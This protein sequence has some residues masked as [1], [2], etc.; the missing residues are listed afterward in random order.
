MIN[1]L[2]RQTER[3]AVRKT[4]HFTTSLEKRKKKK[5]CQEPEEKEVKT[6]RRR[7]RSRTKSAENSNLRRMARSMVRF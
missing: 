6:E 7:R 1:C 5:K 2:S 3:S 4:K